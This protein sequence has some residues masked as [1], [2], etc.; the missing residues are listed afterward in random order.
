[1]STQLKILNPAFRRFLKPVLAHASLPFQ[2]RTWV[3]Y[4]TKIFRNPAG[5]YQEEAEFLY[6]G[7]TV[8]GIWVGIDEGRA[9]HGGPQSVLDMDGA[10]I[11]FHGGGFVAGSPQSCA[12]LAATVAER[13]N[14]RAAV[15]AYRLAPESPFPS[16]C[17]DAMTAY[18]SLLDQGIDPARIFLMGDSSGANLALGLLSRICS[19]GL[20]R[21]AACVAISPVSDLTYSGESFHLNGEADVVLSVGRGAEL[22]QLYLGDVRRDDPLASPLFA[23]FPDCPPVLIHVGSK[24]ILLD[25]ARNMAARLEAF[26]G[27]VKLDIFEDCPHAWHLMHGYLPEADEAVDRIA[28]FLLPRLAR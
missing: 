26:G 20:P 14:L 6:C 8:S 7:S 24:E 11:Y 21:P 3:E 22:N 10:L 25:D 9:T 27:S 17:D 28:K 18:R 23:E 15:P 2:V 12:S 5:F 19:G 16:A 13:L 1:M 4:N